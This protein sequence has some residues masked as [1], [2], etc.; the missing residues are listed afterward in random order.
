MINVKNCIIW[1]NGLVSSFDEKGEQIPECQG[2]ILEIADKLKEHCDENTKWQFGKYG[3]GI[4]DANM[5]WYWE[6]KK[7]PKEVENE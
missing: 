4:L 3:E 2:F 6:A 1:T 5:K 7:Q